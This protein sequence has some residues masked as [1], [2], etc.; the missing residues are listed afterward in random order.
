L[1]PGVDLCAIPAAA[2]PEGHIPNFAN[3]V[4][5]SVE[6]LAVGAVFTVVATIY[7]VGRLYTNRNRMKWADYLTIIGFCMSAAYT[8][9]IMAL[10]PYARHQYDMPA[11]WYTTDHIWKLLFAQNMLLGLTQFFVKAAIL[12]VFFQLFAVNK[13]MRW[14]IYSGVIFSGLIYLP[15]PILVAIFNTPR[16]GERWA[17]LATNGR[18]QMLT[19]YAPI[20]GFGSVILDIFIF[21]VPLLILG[22]LHV[23]TK[24]R[25][26]LMAVFAVG[27]LG[28][29]SSIFSCYWRMDMLVSSNT[30][31]TWRQ[32]QLFIWIMVEHNAAL[33]AGSMPA[34]AAFVRTNVAGSTFVSSLRSR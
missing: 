11:C 13:K 15:H 30:D 7:F 3:P 14:V 5:L 16:A 2:P 10:Y 19:F 8:G 27:I 21:L 9:I 12:V 4:D 23:P 24:K 25:L 1:P 22:K 20:H 6:T 32:A 26:Q 29:I 34:V 18:P 33:I 17:D 31:Y 28:I